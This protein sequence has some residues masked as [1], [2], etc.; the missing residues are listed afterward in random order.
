MPLIT[1]WHFYALAVPCVI[2]LGI[3]KSGFGAGFVGERVT[4]A[5]DLDIPSLTSLPLIGRVVLGRGCIV[6]GV[7]GPR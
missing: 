5:P 6:H 3:S 2:M 4:P 1:D 7:K